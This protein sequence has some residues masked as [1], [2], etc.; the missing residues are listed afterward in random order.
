MSPVYKCGDLRKEMV[1][2]ADQG[3]AQ[4]WLSSLLPT[5]APVIRRTKGL[6]RN[7]IVLYIVGGGVINKFRHILL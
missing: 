4:R 5:P 2:G 7:D 3:W 6:S 1:R